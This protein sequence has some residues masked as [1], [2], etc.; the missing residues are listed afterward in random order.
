MKTSFFLEKIGSL[1]ARNQEVVSEFE[2]SRINNSNFI[3]WIETGA[4][5][6]K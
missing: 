3:D 6:S 2:Q 4:R 1:R 5:C